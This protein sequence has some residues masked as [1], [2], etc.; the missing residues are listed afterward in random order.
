VI[1]GRARLR[2][3]DVRVP[4]PP[5]KL[6]LETTLETAARC[7]SVTFRTSLP[8][9]PKQLP[10][11]RTRNVAPLLLVLVL[12]PAICQASEPTLQSGLE[13]ILARRPHR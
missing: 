4:H 3:F 7:D 12:A 9:T 10:P 11:F 8:L 6:F 1:A 13:Q 2:Q 5:R